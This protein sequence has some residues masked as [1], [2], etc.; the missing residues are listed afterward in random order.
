M[1]VP[2]CWKATLWPFDL[3]GNGLVWKVGNGPEVRIGPDPWVGYKWRH[4]LPSHMLE[5]LHYHGFY[6]LKDIGCPSVSMLME[7]GW[8][9]VEN[10]AFVDL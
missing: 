1:S 4:L 10:V 6:F 9:S 7:Q 2:I 8:I 5:R 3:I